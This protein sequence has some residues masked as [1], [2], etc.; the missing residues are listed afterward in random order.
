[1][2]DVERSIINRITNLATG[3]A[4]ATSLKEKYNL[5]INLDHVILS[6][7]L[8]LEEENEVYEKLDKNVKD[9][10]QNL[11]VNFET[12]IENSIDELINIDNKNNEFLFDEKKNVI[13]PYFQRYIELVKDEQK[14]FKVKTHDKVLWIGSGP[15]PS[16]AM[17]LNSIV[18]CHIDCIDISDAAVNNSR[19]LFKNL[20]LSNLINVIK[21]NGTEIDSS[22]YDKIFIGVLASPINPIMENILEH[23][24]RNVT[25]LK[26]VT[27]GLRNLIYPTPRITIPM[28]QYFLNNKY[29]A[30]GD[31]VISHIIYYPKLGL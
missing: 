24:K 8:S 30:S 6:N 21:A 11:Y 25:L 13:V 27:Y 26:R 22:H 16:S 10:V 2:N 9:E 19:K 1:M 31:Q 28:S 5:I 29:R 3:V 4:K 23:S 20:G 12:D 17:I 15:F 18:G 14:H 7:L